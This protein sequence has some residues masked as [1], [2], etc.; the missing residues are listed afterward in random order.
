MEGDLKEREKEGVIVR[1]LRR[2][3]LIYADGG[4]RS[5]LKD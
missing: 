3:T 5:L 2:F 4:I 1:R